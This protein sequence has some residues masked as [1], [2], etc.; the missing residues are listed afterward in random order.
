M[1]L[2]PDVFLIH[3]L[4]AALIAESL[5]PFTFHTKRRRGD[6]THP[7]Q[8]DIDLHS[9]QEAIQQDQQSSDAVAQLSGADAMLGVLGKLDGLHDK[10]QHPVDQQGWRDLAWV[11]TANHWATQ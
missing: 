7:A 1:Q 4:T 8:D 10:G 11:K 3:S 2:A 6:C 9:Q 5:E